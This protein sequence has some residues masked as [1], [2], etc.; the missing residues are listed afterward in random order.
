MR[1]TRFI[2]RLIVV[3]AVT[4]GS[5]FA[6]ESEAVAQTA[7]QVPEKSASDSPREQK[8]V[9]V[10][11][12]KKTSPVELDRELTGT[13][14][15]K[16]QNSK[17][18]AQSKRK[19]GPVH[20]SQMVGASSNV[21]ARTSAVDSNATGSGTI[22]AVVGQ[23]TGNRKASTP[24]PSPSVAVNGQQFRNPHDPGA[25]LAST[26]GPLTASRGTA[27]INGTNIKRKP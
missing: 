22:H 13:V 17:F 8:A 9:A 18:Q 19:T 2:F 26:G 15:P 10:R 12:D 27:A 14:R 24:S 16:K 6:R 5:G 7:A 11:E 23:S 25:R 4:Q 21:P 20:R 3:A 1:I